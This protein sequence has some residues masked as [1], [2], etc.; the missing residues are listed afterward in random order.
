MEKSTDIQQIDDGFDGM[1]LW[2]WPLFGN[3]GVV[4]SLGSHPW[5]KLRFGT[6]VAVAPL[7]R[8]VEKLRLT[9]RR[10]LTLIEG[11]DV[12]VLP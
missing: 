8:M 2:Q 1:M 3:V 10:P 11:V 7:S 9:W 5:S 4:V 6:D 12:V